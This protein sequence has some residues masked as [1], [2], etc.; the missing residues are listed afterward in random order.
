[1]ETH[2][3]YK[4]YLYLLISF[5]LSNSCK[6]LIDCVINKGPVLNY[7]DLNVGTVNEFYSDYISAEIKNEPSDNSYDYYFGVS[8]NLPV[9][10]EWYVDNRKVVF[11]GTPLETGNFE[12][13]IELYVE[14]SE[15]WDSETDTWDDDLCN[16]FTSGKFTITI[17]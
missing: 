8:D 15:D 11:E 2:T 7:K 14:G 1:M 3:N 9:G 13:K 10:L 4:I 6:D 17:N 12:F 16:D 5:T